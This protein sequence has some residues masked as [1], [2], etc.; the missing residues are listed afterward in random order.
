[1]YIG[2]VAKP[3]NGFRDLVS[4]EIKIGLRYVEVNIS[5][6]FGALTLS[7]I[8]PLVEHSGVLSV[9]SRMVQEV[10]VV[11]DVVEDEELTGQLHGWGGS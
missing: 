2:L 5:A 9:V 11:R 3:N 1:M 8:Q 4:H 6:S 10:H 7:D